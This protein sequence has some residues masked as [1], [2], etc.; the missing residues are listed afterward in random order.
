MT[1]KER[2]RGPMHGGAADPADVKASAKR[3]TADSP[4]AEVADMAA[5]ETSPDT[6]VISTPNAGSNRPSSSKAG[7]TARR[8]PAFVQR[9]VNSN[10][11]ARLAGV[12]RSAVS[13]TFTP[14]ASVAPET[15]ERVLRA[16]QALSYR[17]NLL[18]R[19]LINQRSDLVGVVLSGY[20]DPFRSLQI[21][22][23]TRAIQ[24]ANLRP[25]IVHA[26]PDNDVGQVIGQLLHYLVTG[27]IVTSD[28][29][30]REI[31]DECAKASVPVLVI[32]R[33]TIGLSVD[34][35]VCDNHDGARQALAALIAA[36]CDRLMV[37]C[38]EAP[39]FTLSERLEAFRRGAAQ[40]RLPCTVMRSG[41][42][43]YQHGELVGRSL[44]LEPA[45]HTGAFVVTDYIA[46]G[47]IDGVRAAG[48]HAVPEDLKVV[49]FDDVVIAGWSAYQL[50]TIRQPVDEMAQAALAILQQRIDSPGTP[51]A[52]RLIPVDLIWRQSLGAAVT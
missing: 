23:L 28:T 42:N 30:P 36:G 2:G 1:V 44:K 14:G 20:A 33:N 16:A 25:M 41:G 22:A 43:S 45:A 37:V 19:G 27:I 31:V 15:R 47:L 5:G 39:S 21:A 29:P 49:G 26:D 17:V 51:I 8:E 10:D 3:T 35:L 34:S 11:V 18:A 48:R 13:R 50:A 52:R 4:G 38:P 24:Q 9:P 40:A 6:P 46:L 32:N 7:G 12:S